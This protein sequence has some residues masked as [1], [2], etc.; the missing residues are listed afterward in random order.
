[1]E[2]KCVEVDFLHMMFATTGQWVAEV[3]LILCMFGAACIGLAMIAGE[4]SAAPRPV[5]QNA[6]E[7]SSAGKRRERLEL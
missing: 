1:V 6:S 7:R 5:K 3:T 4:G 2:T